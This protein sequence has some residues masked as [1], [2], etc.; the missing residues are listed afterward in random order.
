MRVDLYAVAFSSLVWRRVRKLMHCPRPR[1]R[2]SAMQERVRL[3]SRLAFLPRSNASTMLKRLMRTACRR[4]TH[5]RPRSCASIQRMMQKQ[6]W[7]L[8]RLCE[9]SSEQREEGKKRKG[10]RRVAMKSASREADKQTPPRSDER[11]RIVTHQSALR[12]P[13]R[14]SSASHAQHR[15][16]TSQSRTRSIQHGSRRFHKPARGRGSHWSG[17][18][19][20]RVRLCARS[21]TGDHRRHARSIR[22]RGSKKVSVISFTPA[23]SG[24]MGVPRGGQ[25]RKGSRQAAKAWRQQ[26]RRIRQADTQLTVTGSGVIRQR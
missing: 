16:G 22:R 18:R 20:S 17:R 2:R 5:S 8:R 4:R 7:Q 14:M 9:H 10:E 6:R 26:R 12:S 25:R 3:R 23:T 21:L 24:V 19:S 13:L 1:G 11:P 15:S